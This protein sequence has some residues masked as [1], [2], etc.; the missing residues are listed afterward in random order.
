MPP[1][2]SGLAPRV[3]PNWQPADGSAEPPRV[4]Q[5]TPDPLLGAPSAPGQPLTKPLPGDA[6]TPSGPI[7]SAP[8]TPSTPKLYP[9]EITENKVA[10]NKATGEPPLSEKSQSAFPPP[11]SDKKSKASFPA[12]IAQFTS[13]MITGVSTGV[14]PK[15]D[16]GLDW[17]ADRGYKT[18]VRLRTPAEEEGPDRKLIE[19]RFRMRYI[20]F[21]ISP[22]TV[23]KAKLDEF[24]KLVTDN[25]LQPIFVY[26]QDGSLAGP[27][28][29]LYFRKFASANDEAARVRT[30]M[31]A[32]ENLS[33]QQK[34]MWDAVQQY[35]AANP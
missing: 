33:G 20:S 31:P 21:E 8:G 7:A 19:E 11:S 30:R 12:G 28:W 4:K 27:F 25:S 14:H 34:L 22:E 24:A 26:D 13:A 35:L 9:P 2:T 29:Y 10:D 32:P 5:T 1:S 18:V 3:E 17:L 16:D 15:L 6:T 23:G